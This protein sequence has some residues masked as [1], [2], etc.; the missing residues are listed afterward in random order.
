M[1][2]ILKK[3][4][5][6]EIINFSNLAISK[7][8]RCNE[9]YFYFYNFNFPAFFK[10]F[11]D[12]DFIPLKKAIY[13]IRNGKDVAKENYSLLKT[14]YFYLTVN[15]I[16]KDGIVFED[17]IFL[18]EDKGEELKTHSLKEDDLIITRSGTVGMCKMFNLNGELTYIPSG[19]LIVI[20]IDK[21][22]YEPKFL[23]Y[24]L[25]SL[26]AQRYFNVHASGKTQKNI[27]QP[28]V[29]SIPIPA[30]DLPA[31]KKILEKIYRDVESKVNEI[32]G[33]VEPL[34]KIIDDVFEKNRYST[35]P[36]LIRDEKY[37]LQNKFSN[38]SKTTWLSARPYLCRFVEDE[39][40]LF[41]KENLK[42]KY[43][44]FNKY[45]KHIRSGEYIPKRY[46]SSDEIDFLYLRVNNISSNELNLKDP[47]FL[48]SNIGEQYKNIAIDT[49]DLIL[50]RSGT[51][52]KCIIFNRK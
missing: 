9:D 1:E 35:R 32:E 12:I 3:S 13:S 17:K 10:L 23:E 11:P 14:T 46:Y 51:V 19:N 25:S 6:Q 45:V 40:P 28:D 31:Q 22:M 18:E 43:T 21:S 20:E 52:G 41:L 4:P 16:K 34:S 33:W 24:Y 47:I 29:L 48:A 50:T 37:I 8:L 44:S 15:N 39:L 38:L 26:F 36:K 49:N 27:S 5:S 2:E 7:S 42:N 30:L